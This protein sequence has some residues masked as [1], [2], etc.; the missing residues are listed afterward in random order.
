L[1]TVNAIEATSHAP[2]WE[3]VYGDIFKVLKS[4]GTVSLPQFFA[5]VLSSNKVGVYGWCMADDLDSL[6]PEHK[7]LVHEIELGYG[8]PRMLPSL[9]SRE[10][11]R[12]VG[13]DVEHGEDL[14]ERLDGELPGAGCSLPTRSCGL[15]S[16]WNAT[17]RELPQYGEVRIL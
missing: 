3:S 6:I 17:G 14:A 2:T 11:L 1:D 8:I 5:L 9:K 15:W 10:A 16:S 7:A 4:G 12:T 13:F